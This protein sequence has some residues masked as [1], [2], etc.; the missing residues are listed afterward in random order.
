MTN[1]SAELR[2]RF[3]LLDRASRDTEMQRLITEQC[4]RDPVQWINDWVWTADPRRAPSK[5]P[6]ALFPRQAEFVRWLADRLKLKESGV[7]EKSR[8]VGFTW[9]CVAFVVHRWMFV[10]GF[11][12]TF[13]SRKESLVDK[14]GDPDSIFEK[15]RFILRNLPPWM[16]PA[17]Q[18]S[19]LRL[20]NDDN[21]STITGE[22][23]DN[24]GRG[25]RSSLYVKDEAAFIERPHLVEAATSQNSDCIIDVS[26]PNGQGNPFYTK[27]MSGKF[28][29][30]TFHWR[31]DPRKDDAWYQKQCDTLDAVTVAQEIDID[32]AASIAGILIT[33]AWA[34]AANGRKLYDGERGAITIGGDLAEAGPDKCAAVVREG[35]NILHMSEWHDPEARDSPARFIALGKIF[36]KRLKPWHKLFFFLDTL[37]V[38]AG[39]AGT[40]RNYIK[41]ED[42]KQWSIVGVKASEASPLDTCH[43][44]KDA[45]WWRMR[46]WYK[47]AEP[48]VSAEV[49][50]DLRR[51]LALEVSTP[52]YDLH[53][54][55]GLILVESK[56]DLKARGVKSPNVADALMH[57]FY[58]EAM[59]G[60]QPDNEWKQRG[61]ET[62]GWGAI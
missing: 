62:T 22:A 37:G 30:F 20:I 25:G 54:T 1:S 53:K 57:S 50:D 32:Y 60:Q 7:A 41:A 28:P 33:R 4:R 40:L 56:H 46:E 23:G 36:E 19:H 17:F 49:P 5:L 39:C 48:A 13:G 14:S 44:L 61:S 52:T 47:L 6:L 18:S 11:K 3:D 34:D 43:R 12:G 29:V 38:G 26:T 42:K 27:R 58:F 45:L 15:A 59:K 8:D 16:V 51:K 9:L 24:M 10:K 31:D 35:R 55:N 2:R 21:G